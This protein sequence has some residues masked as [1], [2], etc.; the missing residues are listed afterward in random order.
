MAVLRVYWRLTARRGG[1]DMAIDCHC[2]SCGANLKVAEKHAGHRVKCP[3][4]TGAITVPAADAPKELPVAKPIAP[5]RRRPPVAAAGTPPADAAEVIA[6]RDSTGADAAEGGFPNIVVDPQAGSPAGRPASRKT[7]TKAARK[8]KP[9][10]RR[11]L[12]LL[13]SFA[14]AAVLAVAVIGVLIYK[15]GGIGLAF[16]D[17]EQSVLVLKWPEGERKDAAV[18]IDGRPQKL[19]RSGPVEYPLKPGAHRIVMLRIGYE[20]EETRISLKAGQRRGYSPVWKRIDEPPPPSPQGWLHDLEVAQRRA[21]A[22]HKDLLIAL[23]GSE[24]GEKWK[25]M[26]EEVFDQREFR[27]QMDWRF[28]L[29]RIDFPRKDETQ[30]QVAESYRV[31]KTS[32]VVLANAEGRPYAAD[33]YSEAD[34]ETLVERLAQRQNFGERLRGQ[35]LN[36]EM[37][38]GDEQLT[39]IKEAAAVLTTALRQKM[40]LLRFYESTLNQWLAVARQRDAEN[41][42]GAYEAVFGVTWLRRLAEVEE[43][44]VEGIRRVVGELDDWKEKY[45]FKD[46]NRGA[47]M[48]AYA[49]LRLARAEQRSEGEKYL[50]QAGAYKPD[51]QSALLM[52]ARVMMAWA[53]AVLRGHGSSGTGFAVAA[54]GYILTNHHV[55]EGEGANL[56]RLPGRKEP[57][58]AK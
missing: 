48:H 23:E 17:Q 47:L 8:S 7:E 3:K 42:Q 34:L 30:T 13:A 11:P 12:W 44:D 21:A 22:E 49:A 1:D 50:K 54:G 46:S 19:P 57:V 55:I 52:T 58:P 37:A 10:T 24:S 51:D 14:S 32:I 35:L 25:K 27:D 9:K 56:V 40:E 18:F 28:V 5:P 2:P 43:K 39:A 31:S 4:C 33:R 38:K 20:Q 45:K 16:E 41:E 53:I 15:Y 6:D 36:V 26:R 29:V